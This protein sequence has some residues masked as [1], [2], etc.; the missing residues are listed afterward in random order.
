M[1]VRATQT[2]SVIVKTVEGEDNIVGGNMLKLKVVR[3]KVECH[4]CGFPLTLFLS[5]GDTVR[6]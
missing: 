4:G 1:L 3:A 6:G 5:H 2:S